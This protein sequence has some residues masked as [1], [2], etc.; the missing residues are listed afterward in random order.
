MLTCRVKHFEWSRWLETI[1]S[2]KVVGTASPSFIWGIWTSTLLM[3]AMLLLYKLFQPPCIACWTVKGTDVHISVTE[4]NVVSSYSW[5]KEYQELAAARSGPPRAMTKPGTSNKQRCRINISNQDGREERLNRGGQ[6]CAIIRRKNKVK[7]GKKVSMTEFVCSECVP[8]SSLVCVF[9]RVSCLQG[10]RVQ[11]LKAWHTAQYEGAC[12]CLCVRGIFILII[13]R[14]Q[15]RVSVYSN[16]TGKN[17]RVV[18]MSQGLSLCVLYWTHTHTCRHT[19]ASCLRHSHVI[20]GQPAVSYMVIWL[21]QLFSTS[22][23]LV[24]LR[25]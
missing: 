22:G 15:I 17:R 23:L 2:T 24:G 5:A 1:C 10:L 13:C 20:S 25:A 7:K 21:L 14:Y 9:Y 4:N 16:N 11:D 3:I 6:I 12:V 19:R 18:R 8:V